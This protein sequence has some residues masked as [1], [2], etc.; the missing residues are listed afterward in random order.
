[1][2]VKITGDLER[3]VGVYVTVNDEHRAGLRRLSFHLFPVSSEKNV[4]PVRPSP[5]TSI[6]CPDIGLEGGIF[7]A[8]PTERFLR[9]LTRRQYLL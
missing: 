3:Y 5:C 9:R 4:G 1:M 8:D 6:M 7:S 2:A